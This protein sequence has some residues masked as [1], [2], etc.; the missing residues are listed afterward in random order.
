MRTQHLFLVKM[1]QI[2]CI[3]LLALFSTAAFSQTSDGEIK[4][5]K[6][7]CQT[8]YFIKKDGKWLRHGIWK[9]HYASAEYD[10]GKMVW[11]EL[12]DGRKFTTEQIKIQQLELKIARLEERIASN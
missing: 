8:G 6:E 7:D 12:K 11:I 10:N 4:K 9:H 1:A 5:Y 2:V 3:L